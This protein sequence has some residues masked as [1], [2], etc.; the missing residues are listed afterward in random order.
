MQNNILKKWA[1]R[2]IL[3]SSLWEHNYFL[4]LTYDDEHLP[5]IDEWQGKDGQ[6]Y[7]DDGSWNGYL[8]PTHM[9]KFLKDIRDHFRYHF[10]HTGIRFYYCGEYG[11][12]TKR[13]HFHALMF[14]FPIPTEYLQFYKKNPNGDILYKSDKLSE[15]WGRGYVVVGELNWD[16]CAYTARYVMKKITGKPSDE[17]YSSKGQTQEMVRMSRMPGLAAKYYE[18]HKDDIYLTD[19]IILKAAKGKPIEIK[20]P[21]YYDRLYDIEYPSDLQRLKMIRKERAIEAQ[22]LKDKTTSLSRKA[23]LELEERTLRE[24]MKALHRDL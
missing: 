3:E 7:Y 16:T 1:N 8:N 6:M 22:K 4:T 19:S 11:S 15:I 9:T 5:K 12:K 21:S 13:P 14:N 17:Y 20:P 10:N 24:K 2:C 18:L 23:Q